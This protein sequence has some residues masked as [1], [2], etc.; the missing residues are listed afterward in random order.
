MTNSLTHSLED[1][2]TTRT[3]TRRVSAPAY[4]LGRPAALWLAALATRTSPRAS[5]VG[6]DAPPV[7]GQP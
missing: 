1:S 6:D 4:Y 5:Y 3:R 2:M 7:S